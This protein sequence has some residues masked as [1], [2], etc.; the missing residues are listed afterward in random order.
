MQQ[1]RRR[2]GTAG[3]PRRPRELRMANGMIALAVLIGVLYPLWGASALVILALD[4][5]V[6]RKVSTLRATFG[7]R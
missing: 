6:I 1:Q 7:Q 5:F 3:L 2:P 4:R